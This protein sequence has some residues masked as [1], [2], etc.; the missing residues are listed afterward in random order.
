MAIIQVYEGKELTEY[1]L[2]DNWCDVKLY[3][4]CNFINALKGDKSN[5]EIIMRTIEALTELDLHQINRMPYKYMFEIYKHL[6][7][8][9]D[10]EPNNALVFKLQ[11]K[12]KIY[13]FN[14]D[15]H[16]MTMGEFVDLETAMEN[17]YQNM[18]KIMCILYRKVIKE[19]GSKYAIEEYTGVKEEDLEFMKDVSMDIVHSA[20]GFF[21]TLK[22]ELLENLIKSL[23]D[24]RTEMTEEGYKK[25]L[26]NINKLK[27]KP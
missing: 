19:E 24:M 21:L 4:Y 6:N 5:T 12:D 3:Q 17:P 11:G 9:L 1:E 13:G 20:S 2:P 18:A 23:E 16:N 10:K 22:K 27:N 8:L 25:T 14:P 7:Q 26:K 15:L